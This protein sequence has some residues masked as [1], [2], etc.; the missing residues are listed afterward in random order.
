MSYDV[1]IGEYDGNYTY[2]VSSLFYDYM[3]GGL[4]AL[5]GMTGRQAANV[6]AGFWSRVNTARIADPAFGARYDAPNGW[7]DTLGALIFIGEITAACAQHPRH[8]MR[9]E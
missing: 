2:N 6:L 8:L 9:V 4:P 1:S 5:D 3:E 7:G